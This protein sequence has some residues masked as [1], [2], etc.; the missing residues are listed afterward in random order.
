MTHSDSGWYRPMS[1]G[2][3]VCE[4][5][6][7]KGRLSTSVHPD[8]RHSL[9]AQL[10]HTAAPTVWSH[11]HCH[12]FP[13]MMD[14]TSKTWA[15]LSFFSL[16]LIFFFFWSGVFPQTGGKEVRYGEWVAVVSLALQSTS[17][18]YCS[19]AV[20]EERLQCR[21]EKPWPVVSWVYWVIV[22]WKARMLAESKR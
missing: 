22:M 8:C 1:W 17:L 10:P 9:A 21:L 6:T 13:A 14:Y 5:G 18:W 20:T 4:R 2:L 15:R 3:R 11:A 16:N 7:Q 12:S 19:V